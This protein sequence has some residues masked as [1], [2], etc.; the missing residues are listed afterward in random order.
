ME[1]ESDAEAAAYM[2][3]QHRTK[4]DVVFRIAGAQYK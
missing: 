3:D 4:P 2:Q 1:N